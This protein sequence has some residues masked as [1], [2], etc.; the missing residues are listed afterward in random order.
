MDESVPAAATTD[1][2]DNNNNSEIIKA[3]S[4]NNSNGSVIKRRPSISRLSIRSANLEQRGRRHSRA[5]STGHHHRQVL[6]DKRSVQQ[7]RRLQRATTQA[8]IVGGGGGGRRLRRVPAAKTISSADIDNNGSNSNNE[9]NIKQNEE[10]AK[11]L[12]LLQLVDDETNDET[13]EGDNNRALI[14]QSSGDFSFEEEAGA[15]A[16]AAA[17]AAAA[18]VE[19]PRPRSV[20]WKGD[21][22]VIYYAGDRRGKLIRRENEP[23]REESDQQARK[24]RYVQLALA[25]SLFSNVATVATTASCH[26]RGAPPNWLAEWPK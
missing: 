10:L 8:Q 7:L 9:S 12:E 26:L 24:N 17:A 22:D 19:T 2:D 13:A 3:K 21:V 14:D 15:C 6:T 11:S 16:A 23:L 1:D 18:A 25:K 4:N 5:R 20:Q